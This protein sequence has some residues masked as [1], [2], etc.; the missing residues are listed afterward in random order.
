MNLITNVQLGSLIP[1]GLGGA[2]ATSI[3]I[4]YSFLLKEFKQTAYK[5]IWI[6][7]IGDDIILP[8]FETR[9]LVNNFY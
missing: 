5:Q 2:R 1:D 9:G 8:K 3:S 4:I 7:Q 6:N